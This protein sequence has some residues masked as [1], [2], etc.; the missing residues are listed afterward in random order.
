MLNVKR[1]Y[2]VAGK[3]V[4]WPEYTAR[5]LIREPVSSPLRAFLSGAICLVPLPRSSPILPKKWG[6]SLWPALR[7]CEALI[8]SGIGREIVP[9]LRRIEST[10]KSAT[11]AQGERPG[12]HEH[13]AT[14]DVQLGALPE[15][16]AVLLVDDVITRGATMLGSAWRLQAAFPTVAMKGFAIALT[17]GAAEDIPDVIEPH[18]GR[19]WDDGQSVRREP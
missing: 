16:A 18:V 9:C 8:E 15:G 7:I 4:R 1:D 5:R 17:R 19:I 2:P 14:I 10:R 12:P 3:S 13:Y 11:A 6:P